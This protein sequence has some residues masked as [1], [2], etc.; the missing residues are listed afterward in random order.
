MIPL[1][2]VYIA[3]IVMMSGPR[4]SWCHQRNGKCH[5]RQVTLYSNRVQSTQWICLGSYSSNQTICNA[6]SP[7]SLAGEEC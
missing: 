6:I 7:L 4:G 3:S 1:L 2:Y 5:V